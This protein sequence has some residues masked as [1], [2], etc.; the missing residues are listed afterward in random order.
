MRGARYTTASGR[1]FDFDAYIEAR[2]VAIADAMRAPT[3]S[4][5]KKKP[6]EPQAT[7]AVGGFVGSSPR[8]VRSR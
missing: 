6:A 4:P 3:A 2:D 5:A 7:H 1:V 8:F